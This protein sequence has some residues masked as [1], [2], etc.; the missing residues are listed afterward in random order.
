MMKGGLRSSTGIEKEFIANTET[1]Y[2]AV[3]TEEGP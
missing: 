1:R 2:A 3:C